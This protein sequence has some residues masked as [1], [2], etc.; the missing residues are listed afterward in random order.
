LK[1]I[2]GALCVILPTDI[3]FTPVAATDFTFLRF[4]FP[5]ASVS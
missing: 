4:I 5:E 2:A 1:S 3:L